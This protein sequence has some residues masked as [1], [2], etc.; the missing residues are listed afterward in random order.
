MHFMSSLDKTGGYV[1]HL[2]PTSKM[3]EYKLL[4]LSAVISNLQMQHT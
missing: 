1:P 4:P 3:K 2:S